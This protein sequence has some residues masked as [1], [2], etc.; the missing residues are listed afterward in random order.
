[1]TITQHLKEVE[2]YQ[3]IGQQILETYRNEGGL[4]EDSKRVML[5]FK[6]FSH[7]R[8]MQYIGLHYSLSYGSD[9]D[10]EFLFPKDMLDNYDYEKMVAYIKQRVITEN[11]QNLKNMAEQ[12]KQAEIKLL[13]Q[14][15]KKY[16]EIT[17]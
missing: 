17:I 6:N 8:N 13:K 5:R 12:E 1:M 14:L 3:K 11:E 9:I 15:Q 4:G 2:D 16:P 10:H 7:V